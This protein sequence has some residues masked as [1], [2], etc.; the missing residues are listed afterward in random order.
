MPKHEYMTG[1]ERTDMGDLTVITAFDWRRRQ[2]T[3]V[4]TA[5]GR[6]VIIRPGGQH[7]DVSVPTYSSEVGEILTLFSNS[8]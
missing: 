8:V 5:D 3:L 1:L 2:W 6:D 4:S 7:I